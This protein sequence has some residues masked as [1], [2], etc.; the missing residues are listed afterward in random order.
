MK[1]KRRL[2]FSA[3]PNRY[4]TGRGKQSLM[5]ALLTVSVSVCGCKGSKPTSDFVAVHIDRQTTGHSSL[6]V[7]V[8]P[9]QVG[10]FAPD[11]KS[12]SGYF[13]DDVLEY[14]VWLHPERGAAPLNGSK[15]YFAA[16]A[17]YEAAEQYSKTTPGSEA[18]LVL[19]RQRQWIDEPKRGE[20]LAKQG[21]R[22][23]EWQ[24]AWL[25]DSKRS[26]TSVDDFLKHPYEA[27]PE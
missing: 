14:R 12:G 26:S 25:K 13:Y 8:D 18:P 3:G 4:R 27:D 21:E 2:I 19:V 20:F 23:T 17:Q 11:T 6:P 15:D 1:T 16:F 7:A 22:V 5:I 10:T 9:S 24:T